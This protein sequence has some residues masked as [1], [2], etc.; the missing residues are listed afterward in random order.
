MLQVGK[1]CI[2]SKKDSY[3]DF[4]IDFGGTAVWV[5]VVTG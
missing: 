3:T 4:H 5:P 2:M 1:Y